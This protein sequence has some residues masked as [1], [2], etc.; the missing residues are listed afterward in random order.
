MSQM[1]SVSLRRAEHTRHYSIRPLIG[2]GWEVRR[3][4]DRELTRHACYRD[5]HRVERALAV[6]R[7]EVSELTS[8]GWAVSDG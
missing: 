1:F 3:E 7:M 6:F 2:S 5:W 4:E 8:S